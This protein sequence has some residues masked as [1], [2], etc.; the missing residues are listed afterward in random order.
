MHTDYGFS[1]EDFKGKTIMVF[2]LKILKVKPSWF[3]L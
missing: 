3:F 1:S 2:P